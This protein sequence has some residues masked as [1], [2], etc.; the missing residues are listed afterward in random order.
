MNSI[1]ILSLS[2]NSVGLTWIHLLP[3]KTW[4]IVLRRYR[5]R[6]SGTKITEKR[7]IR[8]QSQ[9]SNKSL[10]KRRKSLKN[11]KSKKKRRDKAIQEVVMAVVAVETPMVEVAVAAVVDVVVVAMNLEQRINLRKALT[12]MINIKLDQANQSSKSRRQKTWRW[13]TTT[14]LLLEVNC[15]RW[16]PGC[17]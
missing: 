10:N 2:R 14:I 6:N 9:N 13:T 17:R 3:L 11:L 4:M 1:L 5:R 12:Q 8:R 16:C 15:E 7:N